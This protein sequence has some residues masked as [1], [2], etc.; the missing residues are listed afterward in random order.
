MGVYHFGPAVYKR[1]KRGRVCRGVAIV[2]CWFGVL[3]SAL[4]WLC[5][6]LLYAAVPGFSMSTAVDL[7]GCCVDLISGLFGG[8]VMLC[9]AMSGASFHDRRCGL[10]PG[11][12]RWMFD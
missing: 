11:G 5:F 9:D 3:W 1:M 10:W 2:S 4:L 7:S 8:G 12:S 6:A